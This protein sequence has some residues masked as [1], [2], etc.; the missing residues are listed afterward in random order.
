MCVDS[1]AIQDKCKVLNRIQLISSD[2]LYV[3]LLMV[4]FNQA[5]EGLEFIPLEGQYIITI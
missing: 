4:T 2:P 1:F 5:M 3:D